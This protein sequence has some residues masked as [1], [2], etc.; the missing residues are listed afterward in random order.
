MPQP[1]RLLD[2]VEKYMAVYSI[3]YDLQK[4]KNYQK[5]HQGIDLLSKQ[6][7]IKPTLSQFLIQTNLSSSQIMEFLKQ[8]VDHDDAIFVAKVGIPDWAA[9]NVDPELIKSFRLFS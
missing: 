5:L 2:R 9:Y 8:Y 6:V 7:W 1:E 4:I 3:T